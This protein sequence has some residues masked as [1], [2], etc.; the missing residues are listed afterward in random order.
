[1][2]ILEKINY[3][4]VF[5]QILFLFISAYGYETY[6]LYF[7]LI[8]IYFLFINFKK[9]KLNKYILLLFLLLAFTNHYAIETLFCFFF[10]YLFA[11]RLIS[12][13]QVRISKTIKV[14]LFINIIYVLFNAFQG[15][16]PNEFISASR[17]HIG[18]PFIFFGSLNLFLENKNKL[19]SNKLWYFFILLICLWSISRANIIT[20]ALLFLLSFIRFNN[21]SLS[22]KYKKAITLISLSSLFTFIIYNLESIKERLFEKSFTLVKFFDDR[23]S[24]VENERFEIINK[25]LESLNGFDYILGKSIEYNVHNS[26]FNLHALLGVPGILFFIFLLYKTKRRLIFL[27]PI[28]LRSS[29]DTVSFFGAELDF[30]FY[31]L[32]FV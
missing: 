9:I 29:T 16:N 28:L 15:I 7:V 18:I 2:K 3:L 10:S 6:K 19:Y 5:V 25:Y 23:N 14:V 20:G 30:I 4:L 26:Y 1:M 11:I 21:I 32:A 22:S 8:E 17:N 27:I 13:D 24:I 31:Y 12:L